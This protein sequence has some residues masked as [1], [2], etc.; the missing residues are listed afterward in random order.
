MS[1]S[2]TEEYIKTTWENGT[3]PINDSNLNKIEN[4]LSTLDARTLAANTDILNLSSDVGTLKCN[5]ITNG[6][7]VPTGRTI[8]GHPE[9]IKRI[10]TSIARSTNRPVD[11]GL[12]SGR[13]EIINT[14]GW[15]SNANGTGIK[16]RDGFVY[17]NSDNSFQTHVINGVKVQVIV[18]SGCDW[19]TANMLCYL[20]VRYIDLQG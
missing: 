5:I 14:Q 3:T 16:V 10:S 19:V 20:E 17:G 9:Y 18:G 4:Q 6:P 13:H 12:T 11:T 7:G 2:S 15:I 1:T 8:D